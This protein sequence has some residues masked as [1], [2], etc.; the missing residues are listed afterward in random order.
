MIL[1]GVWN[2][3]FVACSGVVGPLPASAFF[4]SA[5]LVPQYD[6]SMRS[7]SIR[8]ERIRTRSMR[9]V[10]QKGTYIEKYIAEEEVYSRSMR[11]I[12]QKGPYQK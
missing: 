1:S 5:L 8:R 3:A 7:R 10:E 12:W 9:S 4:M 11:S 2:D 6:T